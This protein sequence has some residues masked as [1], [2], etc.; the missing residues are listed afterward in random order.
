M[1]MIQCQKKDDHR[2]HNLGN[3]EDA[4]VIGSVII[5][6]NYLPNVPH[7]IPQQPNGISNRRCQPEITAKPYT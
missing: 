6:E 4:R 3:K 1:S 7:S 5:N 2:G